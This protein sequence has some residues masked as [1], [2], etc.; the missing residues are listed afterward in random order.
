M[1]NN[2]N[3]VVLFLGILLG[4]IIG[5]LSAPTKGATVRSG[6]IYNL[7]LYQKKLK[8]FIL[9]LRNSTHT[10]SNQAK[11]LGQEVITDIVDSAKKILKELE[12][13]AGQLEKQE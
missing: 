11:E 13:L 3:L 1:K 4:S 12:E 2:K 8:Y 5:I 7:K 9:K 6:L 10:M